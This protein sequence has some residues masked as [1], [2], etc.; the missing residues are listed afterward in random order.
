MESAQSNV[1]SLA[2]PLI[3]TEKSIHVIFIRQPIRLTRVELLQGTSARLLLTTP[4]NEQRLLGIVS[5][6]LPKMALHLDISFGDQLCLEGDRPALVALH[7]LL[8]EFNETSGPSCLPHCFLIVS[9]DL[10]VEVHT[11]YV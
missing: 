5:E 10:R 6:R 8:P 4:T 9:K 7:G 1:A 11:N 2:S 3:M